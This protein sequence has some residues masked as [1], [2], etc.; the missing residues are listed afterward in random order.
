MSYLLHRAFFRAR[1]SSTVTKLFY[2]G[3]PAAVGE[4][5][6]NDL[7]KALLRLFEAPQL[8]AASSWDWNCG[9]LKAGLST[10]GNVYETFDT[11]F[12]IRYPN[13]EGFF[14]FLERPTI[15]PIVGY[16][17]KHNIQIQP[18]LPHRWR[19][20]RS[21][22]PSIKFA[23]NFKLLPRPRSLIAKWRVLETCPRSIPCHL[24]DSHSHRLRR[25]IYDNFCS[26][27]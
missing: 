3:S 12:K 21:P 18:W 2:D 17:E 22:P 4:S 11:I 9:W 16:P 19:F 20:L 24:V 8:T 26:V 1:T 6:E 27:W 15:I 7:E 10:D 14:F 25:M 5:S 13:V 23:R